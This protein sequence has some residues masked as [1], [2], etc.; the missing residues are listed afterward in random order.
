[1]VEDVVDGGGD[2]DQFLAKRTR[3][4]A[5]ERGDQ[6][7]AKCRH[8]PLERF[9]I[10]AMQDPDGN[11]DERSVFGAAGVERIA[12]VEFDVA[13]M[14]HL[15][16][17]RVVEI[18]GL[19]SNEVALGEVEKCRVLTSGP[20]PPLVELAAGGDVAGDATIE[21]GELRCFVDQEVVAAVTV[22]EFDHD[23]DL[24]GVVL[25]EVVG[26]VPLVSDEGV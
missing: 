2:R 18:G 12:E 14:P 23:G 24:L 10:E 3:Q 20:L 26:G 5:K 7:T 19:W 1:M 13:V 4:G 17:P 15:G 21:E 22:L 9:G 16:E 11:V 8:V 25:D 6:L